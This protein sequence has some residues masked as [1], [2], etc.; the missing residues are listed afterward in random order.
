MIRQL[1][2]RVGLACLVALFAV[3]PL[4]AG[5]LKPVNRGIEASNV[6]P[7]IAPLKPAPKDAGLTWAKAMI[8]T[9]SKSSKTKV[10]LDAATAD[11]K[12]PSVVKITVGD[13]TTPIPL[14][15][16]VVTY[17]S[18]GKAGSYQYGYGSAI[19]TETI[20]GKAV[21]M[22]YIVSCYLLAGKAPRVEIA[23]RVRMETKV[24]FGDEAGTIHFLDTDGNF[25]LSRHESLDASV[26]KTTVQIVPNAPANIG[27][28]LY[29]VKFNEKTNVAT[30]KAYEGEQGKVASN[31]SAY[32][33]VLASKTLGTHLVTNETGTMTLPAGEYK[34]NRYR[35]TPEKSEL[36][37]VGY[38]AKSVTVVADKTTTLPVPETLT[39]T[40]SAS[41]YKSRVRIGLNM[42]ISIGGRGIQLV[43]DNASYRPTFEI[44]D[45]ENKV[46]YTN[47]LEYG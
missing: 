17:T 27:G 34:I 16:K 46:V 35:V 24:Q 31:L 13:K 45:S 7:R 36:A 21:P 4:L 12:I 2:G 10:A 5:E 38:G 6:Y 39:A 18:R 3:E 1:S 15:F 32:S 11:A 33:Y 37:I 26:G 29:H 30:V 23:R 43:K 41:R 22:S 44:V 47:T 8:G 28:T 25:K 9:L 19:V 14:A 40:L 20:Q 42:T